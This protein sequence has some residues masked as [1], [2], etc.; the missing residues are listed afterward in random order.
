MGMLMG[1]EVPCRGSRI[2]IYN[3]Q[4]G[5]RHSSALQSAVTPVC[6]TQSLQRQHNARSVQSWISQNA[7]SQ[8]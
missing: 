6:L 1:M 3:T 4:K 7:C 2:Q 8:L 5:D